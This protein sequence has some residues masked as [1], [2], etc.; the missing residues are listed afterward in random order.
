[1]RTPLPGPGCPAGS[2]PVGRSR[3][4]RPR[5]PRVPRPSN[6]PSAGPSSTYCRRRVPPPAGHPRGRPRPAEPRSPAIARMSASRHSR[7][8]RAHVCPMVA[9]PTR[10]SR[11]PAPCVGQA[12][13]AEEHPPTVYWTCSLLFSPRTG[14]LCVT[15]ARVRASAVPGIRPE[16]RCGVPAAPTGWCR[17]CTTRPSAGSA[18][19]TP[20][21]QRHRRQFRCGQ[22]STVVPLHVA[23]P[24]A[25]HPV[26]PCLRDL[27]HR[28]IRQ[29][30]GGDGSP[31]TEAGPAVLLPAGRAARHADRSARA[32]LARRPRFV[33]AARAHLN[34]A[35]G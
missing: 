9:T 23:E 13:A 27:P 18:Q 1:M 3:A 34:G 29:D 17:H 10:C 30:H 35:D 33:T 2:D 22:W 28:R 14:T 32:L 8:T 6:G 5:A 21:F 4:A 19:P 7:R 26:P 12:P 24:G 16:D 20:R 25:F 31:H 11:L 15:V